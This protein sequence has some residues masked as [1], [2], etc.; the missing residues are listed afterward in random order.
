MD[1]FD[2]IVISGG[3]TCSFVIGLCLGAWLIYQRVQPQ[4]A[5]TESTADL[6]RQSAGWESWYSQHMPACALLEQSNAAGRAAL[7][8]YEAAR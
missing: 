3:L 6:Q 2:L 1:Y 7:A 5:E 4:A 8:E